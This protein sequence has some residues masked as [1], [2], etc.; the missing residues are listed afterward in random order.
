M[1]LRDLK[2]DMRAIIEARQRSNEDS[3]VPYLDLKTGE[4]VVSID[5]EI[6]GE[7]DEV[8][9]LLESDP[10]RLVFIQREEGSEGWQRMSDFA[11]Q[12]DE[13]DLRGALQA[14]L[15]GRGAFGRF[16]A[17]ISRY[18]DL[19]EQWE[20]A[21][22]N[23]HSREAELWLE[24]LGV[25]AIFDRPAMVRHQ[26]EPGS[27][28]REG[29]K[30]GFLD[31]LLLGAPDGKTELLDGKVI[32]QIIAHDSSQA[33][34][35]FKTIAR[36]MTEIHG[37][38]WRKRFIEGKSVYEVERYR[39]TVDQCRVELEVAVTPALWRAFAGGAS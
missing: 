18:P 24:S 29:E 23:G 19:R 11:A 35:I 1:G 5:E 6:S 25:R 2:V 9:A 26:S 3:T 27:A 37:I 28:K 32:R 20:A 34:A 33:R 13:E 16:R 7:P 14:A 21:E 36:E 22:W 15:E 8:Q 39:L 31:V 4:V 38:G 12:V 17:A 10:E 30:L